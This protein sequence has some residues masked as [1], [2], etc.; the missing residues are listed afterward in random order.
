MAAV[1]LELFLESRLLAL[2]LRA[3]GH[4]LNPKQPQAVGM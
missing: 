4:A 1:L 3:S 2:G